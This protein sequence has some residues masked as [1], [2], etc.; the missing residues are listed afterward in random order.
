[1]T[2]TTQE[3]RIVADP[4]VPTVAITREFASTPDKVFKVYTEQEY[5]ERWLGPDSISTQMDT[6]D[7]RT[8]GSYRYAAIREGEEI[9]TFYG[10]FHEVRPG[11]RIVQT[12][13][14]EGLPDAV[15]LEILTFEELPGGRTLLTGLTVVESMEAQQGMM[16]SG[17]EVGINEGY[18]K[19]DKI[20]EEL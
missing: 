15:C 18:A 8:G 2:A 11:E 12:F 19:L 7:C 14:W 1:M 5:V 10:S 16:A 9:A 20:L 3:A 4:D 6:W 17:M 13:T